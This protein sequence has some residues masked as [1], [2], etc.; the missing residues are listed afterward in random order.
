VQGS[1]LESSGVQA[2]FFGAAAGPNE[3]KGIAGTGLF[4][5]HL[6][7][8]ALAAATE[9]NSAEDERRY[10]ALAQMSVPERIALLR[11]YLLGPARIEWVK[12]DET[13]AAEYTTAATGFIDQQRVALASLEVLSQAS[14]FLD[15]CR[16]LVAVYLA[17]STFSHGTQADTVRMVSMKA[18]PDDQPAAELRSALQVLIMGRLTA[19]ALAHLP[20]S[21]PNGGPP[22]S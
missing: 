4:K 21:S 16:T 5:D 19:F 9:R 7:K 8:K 3:N 11:E 1:K 12:G 6:A 20:F 13:L 10:R 22:S 2:A 15:T 14:G 17:A 18:R